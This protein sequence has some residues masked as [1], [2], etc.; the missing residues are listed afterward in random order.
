MYM[1]YIIAYSLRE[2][3]GAAAFANSTWISLSRGTPSKRRDPSV[4]LGIGRPPKAPLYDVEPER[5]ED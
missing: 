3:A 2:C 1:F 4:C 5:G